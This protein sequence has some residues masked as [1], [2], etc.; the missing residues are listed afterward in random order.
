MSKGI[1]DTD[2][3]AISTRIRA[4]ENGLLSRERVEQLL[5][6][7]TEE[8]TEKLLRESGYPD[9][10]PVRPDAMDAAISALREETFRQIG[11]GT[12]EP[13]DTD[14]YDPCIV[15]HQ[16]NKAEER[17]FATSQIQSTV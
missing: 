15:Y 16:G 4:M 17:Q 5:E 13:Q 14:S 6:A 9:L 1:R 3:L 12:G 7:R 11:E 2:Y 10:D 8:D